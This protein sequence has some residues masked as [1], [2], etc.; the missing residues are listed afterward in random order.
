MCAVKSNSH[1]C[2]HIYLIKSISVDENTVIRNPS[3]FS[4]LPDEASVRIHFFAETYWARAIV[5]ELKNEQQK[6]Q[7]LEE[8]NYG[9]KNAL[10]THFVLR[11]YEFTHRG[12]PSAATS[13]PVKVRSLI[14]IDIFYVIILAVMLP[15]EKFKVVLIYHPASSPVVRLLWEKRVAATTSL[16]QLIWSMLR[17]EGN[18]K[19]HGLFGISLLYSWH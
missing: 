3:W 15:Y 9:W 7:F 1:S 17:S 18:R 10:R 11:I 2:Q 5:L 14:A 13:W 6:C 16:G 8:V 4:C 12:Q 19:T